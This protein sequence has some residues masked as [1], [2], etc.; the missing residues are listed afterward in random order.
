VASVCQ[1]AYNG[2]VGICC[3]DMTENWRHV[4]EQVYDEKDVV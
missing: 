2:T 1:G 4:V 3:G